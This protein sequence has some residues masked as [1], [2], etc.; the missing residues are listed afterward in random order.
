MTKEES[1]GESAGALFPDQQLRVHNGTYT[2][3]HESYGSFAV[4]LYTATRGDLAGRRIVSLL[5]GP[6][7]ETDWRGVGF[8][9]DRS[10]TISVW[11]KY[12]SPHRLHFLNGYYYGEKWSTPERKLAIWTCL[13]VRGATEARHGYW[14]TAGYTLTF[15]TRCVVCNKILT[16]PESI[17]RGVGPN[18]RKVKR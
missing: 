7:E 15:E 8:W 3:W 18:C 1:T 16:E 4:K 6:N 9:H 14:F 13:V 5:M 12:S 11:E 17:R 10:H 2:C